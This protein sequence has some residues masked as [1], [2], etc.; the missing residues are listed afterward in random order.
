MVNGGNIVRFWL[1]SLTVAVAGF[2]PPGVTLAGEMVQVAPWGA[3]A[4]LSATALLNPLG[5][6][7]T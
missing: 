2:C 5:G 3:P 7:Y 6:N 4:Q 1:A